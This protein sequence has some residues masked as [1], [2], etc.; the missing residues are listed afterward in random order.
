MLKYLFC[1][2]ISLLSLSCSNVSYNQLAGDIDISIKAE[3]EAN[4]TVGDN[5]SGVGSETVVFFIFRWPGTKYRAE[6]STMVLDTS[7]PSTFKIPVLSNTLNS[8]NPFN[9]VEHAKGQALH[10]AITSSNADVIINPKFIITEQ[11]FFI[12]KTV[13]CEVTGKKGTIKTIK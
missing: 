4:I 9:V 3:L 5:I 7:S 8:L 1:I 2:T 10:N 11:D 6:G 12:Y 13:K